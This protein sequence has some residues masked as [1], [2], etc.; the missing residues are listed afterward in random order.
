MKK[1]KVCC[2]ETGRLTTIEG[3][4]KTENSTER[5]KNC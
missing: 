2:E 1:K 4:P 5:P 3:N